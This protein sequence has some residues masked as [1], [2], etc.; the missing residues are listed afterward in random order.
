MGGGG[1][2]D[3]LG[4]GSGGG[5]EGGGGGLTVATSAATPP[6]PFRAQPIACREQ[7]VW[8]CFGVKSLGFTCG[9]QEGWEERNARNLSSGQEEEGGCNL[10]PS[11]LQL[12][13]LDH[14]LPP[15]QGAP[16]GL[17]RAECAD[18]VECVKFGV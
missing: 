2:G 4:L 6:H 18:L 15:L 16:H 12:A 13:R 3:G 17:P 8:T 14:A 10:A 11:V 1:V 7:N 9:V 5:S